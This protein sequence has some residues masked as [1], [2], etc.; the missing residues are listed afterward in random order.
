MDTGRITMS[1]SG[2]RLVNPLDWLNVLLVPL[3][4]HGTTGRSIWTSNRRA[5]PAGPACSK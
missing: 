5:P 4:I 1:I 2:V 3:L